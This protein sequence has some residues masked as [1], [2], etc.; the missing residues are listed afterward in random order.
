[1]TVTSVKFLS[2]VR[3]II[4]VECVNYFVSYPSLIHALQ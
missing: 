2:P 3:I 1:M 4:Y